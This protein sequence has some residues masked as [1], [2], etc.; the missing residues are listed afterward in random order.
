MSE[1]L[2]GVGVL[3][4]FAFL[5]NVRCVYPLHSVLYVKHILQ[6]FI[7]EEYYIHKHWVFVFWHLCTSPRSPS[8]ESGGLGNCCPLM[9]LRMSCF[10]G[11]A[12]R[13]SSLN[14]LNEPGGN[15]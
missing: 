2:G 14:G 7:F 8:M 11:Y 15:E 12:G 5:L 3:G 1:R 6:Y 13:G 10:L 4:F 9:I